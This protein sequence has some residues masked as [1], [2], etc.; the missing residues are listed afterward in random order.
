MR[1]MPVPSRCL[2]AATLLAALA[3]PGCAWYDSL[4]GEGFQTWNETLGGGMRGRNQEAQPSGFFTDKRSD[5]I[6]KNLGGGF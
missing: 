3:A 4:R 1:P 5:Q 2:L 6:E